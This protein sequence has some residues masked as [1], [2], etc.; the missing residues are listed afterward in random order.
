M[1]NQLTQCMKDHVATFLLKRC[2][3]GLLLAFGILLEAGSLVAAESEPSDDT[4]AIRQV[5]QLYVD[6]MDKGQKENIQKVFV[7]DAKLMSIGR[8][9]EFRQMTLDEWWNRISGA[10]GR[11]QRTSKITVL[12]VSGLAGAAKVDFG[13]SQDYMTLLKINGEW[14]IVNKVLSTKL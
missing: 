1:L 9:D 12:D 2:C 6:I 4:N 8:N 7:P 3:F 14:K 13:R 11:V 10:A 5:V